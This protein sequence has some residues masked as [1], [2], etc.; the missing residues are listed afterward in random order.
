MKVMASWSTARKRPGLLM[1]RST[2]WAPLS[3]SSMSCWS[4]LRRTVTSEIS[5]ATKTPLSRMRNAMMS[6]SP[7]API[8]AVSGVGCRP[9]AGWYGTR[10][11]AHHR[12]VRAG[13][14]WVTTDPAPVTAPSPM[15]TGARRMVSEPMNAPSPMTVRCLA[16]PS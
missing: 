10:R 9:A 1:S 8:S 7:M 11:D 16:R 12:R 6:S 5:A 14:S 4:R 15:V 2:R 13:T 3:P